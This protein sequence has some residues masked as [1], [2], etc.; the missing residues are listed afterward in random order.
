M[1]LSQDGVNYKTKKIQVLSGTYFFLTNEAIIYER[2][3]YDYILFLSE[4]GGLFGIVMT[5]MKFM[6]KPI[7]FNF[8]MAK[9]IKITYFKNY[10][11]NVFEM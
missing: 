4:I 8:D 5:I 1:N 7:K 10:N 2:H 3:L 9:I 6:I 11:K